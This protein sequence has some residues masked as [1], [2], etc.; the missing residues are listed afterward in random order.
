[1]SKREAKKELILNA[2][3]DVMRR[4]GY[5][6]TGV[7]D[8]VDAAGVPKG[9]FYNYFDS[10][11]AFAVEAMARAA[12]E[13]TQFMRDGLCGS[14]KP[15]KER[16]LEFFQVQ[17]LAAE[18]GENRTGCFIGTLCQEMA[19]SCETI[20]LSSKA[21]FRTFSEVVGEL[22]E[23]GKAD[24][25]ITCPM[26]SEQLADLIINAWQ[27]TLL[28]MKAVRSRRP[29]DDFCTMVPHLLAA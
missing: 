28:R 26:P 12:E 7:K 27:G 3:L 20:R 11:E 24:G 15:P 1:M 18:T 25:S 5:N 17:A 8:I 16:L 13:V 9:S 22:I 2:G 19:G 21:M 4:Q 14:G 29:M 6:G 10:K 23:E